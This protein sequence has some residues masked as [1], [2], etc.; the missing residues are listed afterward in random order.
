MF[1]TKDKQK[2]FGNKFHARR[3]DAAHEVKEEV[4]KPHEVV[5]EHGRATDVSVYHDHD[6]HSH[7]VVS[8][9]EDG[10]EHVSEH[11]T[12]QDAHEEAKKLAGCDHNE[13]GVDKAEE[14]AEEGGNEFAGLK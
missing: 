4:K 12:P 3:Y 14:S 13:E 8:T 2:S 7:K 5:Q 6:K 9:H 11:R 10:F 1:Q